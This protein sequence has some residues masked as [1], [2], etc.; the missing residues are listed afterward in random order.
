LSAAAIAHY[1]NFHLALFWRHNLQSLHTFTLRI[2]ATAAL[3]AIC[4]AASAADYSA[5]IEFDNTVLSG[6]KY[7]GSA[8]K[9]ITQSGRVELNA[10]GK[11]G[12]KLFV[13][14]KAAFLAKKDGTVATDD[15]WVQLGS[16]AFDVKLGRF[17]AANLFP[18]PGDTLVD[19]A[20][21]VFTANSNLRGRKGGNEFHAAATANL[22]GGLSVELGLIE[23]KS[24]AAKGFR[25]A[26]TYS[27]GPLSATL[28]IES[29]KFVA[30]GRKVNSV[31]LSAAYDFGGFK[32]T[33]NLSSGKTDTAGAK[34]GFKTFG[35][36]GSFGSANIGFIN[37]DAENAANKVA[38]VYG[39][40]TLPL[41]D[42]KGASITPAFSTSKQGNVK[43]NGFRVRINYTF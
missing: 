2:T 20:G 7:T 24:G 40:Y 9:G 13:A 41:F 1:S 42:I 10:S 23:T 31:G 25:P 30:S 18:L 39:S 19:H 38:T 29:G 21:D 34:D 43:A 32:V 12:S 36:I 35:L 33:G 3:I 27:S 22:G 16:S 6:S 4:C 14:A 11:A 15:M 28:G 5:N 17:E 8:D 26:L 37:G